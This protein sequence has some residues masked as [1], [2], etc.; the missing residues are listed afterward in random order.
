MICI[1][2]SIKS[3]VFIDNNDNFNDINNDKNMD[4]L[5]YFF[6]NNIIEDRLFVPQTGIPSEECCVGSFRFF[7]PR[8]Q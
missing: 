7:T 6:D 2:I 8:G 4:N 5:N 3:V 1:K